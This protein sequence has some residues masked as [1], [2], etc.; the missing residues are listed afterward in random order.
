MYKNGIDPTKEVGDDA[1]KET[2]LVILGLTFKE[3]TPDTRNP[4]VEVTI[5]RLREYSIYPTVVDPWANE[6]DA[7]HD[8]YVI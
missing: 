7:M 2:N 3:H 4:K 8:Y 6:E 1:I 5:N